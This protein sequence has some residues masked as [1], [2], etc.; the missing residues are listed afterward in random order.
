MFIDHSPV[1]GGAE[2]SLLDLLMRLDDY[3]PVLVGV[4]GE[5]IKRAEEKGI[6]TR[7]L[8]MPEGFI[9]IRRER[10]NLLAILLL[11][12]VLFRLFLIIRRLHPEVIY[13]NTLKAHIIGGILAWIYGIPCIMHI[14]D[15]LRGQNLYLK[16]ISLLSTKMIAISEAVS[17]SIPY[18]QDIDVVYNG[19]DLGEYGSMGIREY[20]RGGMVNIG[21]VGQIA[22]WKG[23]EYFIKSAALISKKYRERIKFWVVGDAVFGDEEYKRLVKELA[24]GLNIEFTGWISEPLELMKE[25]DIIVHIPI[26]DEPFGR[27]LIEAGGLAKPVVATKVGAIPEIVIDGGTGILVPP[28]DILATNNAIC[29][30][31][32]DRELRETMGY[33]ARE[34]VKSLFCLRKTVEKVSKVIKGVC[35]GP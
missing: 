18:G 2:R 29:R 5:T 32:E 1:F 19:I 7:I 25:M 22:R 23:T 26:E 10:R 35:K 13:T 21:I 30:L 15:I 14:R 11:F 6:E 3:R 33:K 20:G 31:V 24:I 28:G 34:R 12:P 8:D 27:V 4:K 16:F 17:H 9:T